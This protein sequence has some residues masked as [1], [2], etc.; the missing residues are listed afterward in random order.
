MPIAGVSEYSSKNPSEKLRIMRGICFSRA[1]LFDMP[2]YYFPYLAAN[3]GTG[4]IYADHGG[5][6]YDGATHVQPM[7]ALEDYA[8]WDSVGWMFE[9]VFDTSLF[10]ATNRFRLFF[11]QLSPSE[12]NTS[13]SAKYVYKLFITFTGTPVL[14]TEETNIELKV[15]NRFQM[16]V[17]VSAED[18]LL[19][20]YVSENLI[21]TSD[22]ENVVMVDA[23][24][25]LTVIAEGE[26][27]ITAAFGEASVSAAVRVGGAEVVPI[28]P[29]YPV[30]ETGVGSGTG[31]GN[32]GDGVDSGNDPGLVQDANPDASA[33]V[34][35]TVS[36]T[37]DIMPEEPIMSTIIETREEPELIIVDNTSGM[38]ILSAELMNRPEYAALVR[39][40]LSRNNIE[41]GGEGALSG[42]RDG[43]MG[44]DAVQLIL[45][46]H[47]PRSFMWVASL[48]FA[49]FFISGFGYGTLSFKR[50]L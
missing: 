44:A 35:E 42:A 33:D 13:S 45:P 49:V 14:S 16:A 26:A 22:N 25:N 9:E 47:E 39:S 29:I 32:H 31:S 17:N 5:D 4:E 41:T 34:G 6:L 37:S 19:D 36:E 43:G 28:A 12:A 2:R 10:S 15:G 1:S 30:T 40:V 50:K 18:A 20:S 27:V 46:L 23:F 7:L 38:Y 11:G 48:A 21:W 8:Q 3:E 24:G